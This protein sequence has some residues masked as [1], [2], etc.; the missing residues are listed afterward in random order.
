MP[1]RI[2]LIL[3]SRHVV[4]LRLEKR[5]FGFWEWWDSGC[6]NYVGPGKDGRYRIWTDRCLVPDIAFDTLDEALA[7]IAIPLYDPSGEYGWGVDLSTY[8]IDHTRHVYSAR[9]GMYVD[10]KTRELLPRD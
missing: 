6:Q 5:A 7:Y 4:D 1:Q 2:T 8:G 10:R 9:W 3:E